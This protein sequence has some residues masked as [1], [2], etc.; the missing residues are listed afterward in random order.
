MSETARLEAGDKAPA[1]SL[2]DADGNT[3]KLS[4]YQGRKVLVYFYPAASTPGCTKEACD[5]RDNLAELNDSGIDVVGISPDK[6]EKLAKFRDAQSLTFPLLSDPDKQVLTAWGAF[7]EKKMYG[8]TVQGVI[9]STFLVDEKGKIE[10][11]QYNVRATGHVA[12]LRKDLS[13]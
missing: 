13:V 6:P 1:F 8:K 4:D 11:A 12:K 10:V 7:G 5:F 9:R 2:T 3:V